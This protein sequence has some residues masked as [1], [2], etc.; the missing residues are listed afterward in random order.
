M[1]WKTWI[2]LVFAVVLALVA[3]KLTHNVIA[4][5]K[6][7]SDQGSGKFVQVVVARGNLSAGAELNAENLTLA[8][9]PGE[10]APESTYTAVTDLLGRVAAQ[11]F[12]LGQPI[13][14]KML[15]PKGAGTG[16]Q[17]LIPT[18]F[19]AVTLEINEFTGIAGLITPGMTVDVV[20]SFRDDSTRETVTRTVVQN[21]KVLAVGPRLSPP[22]SD[23]QKEMYKSVTLLAS[24]RDA[25]RV[26]LAAHTGRPRLAL[27]GG[28]DMVNIA[29]KGT[30][31]SDLAN[32]GDGNSAMTSLLAKFMANAKAAKPTTQPLDK[33]FAVEQPKAKPEVDLVNDIFE[34]PRTQQRTVK[35]IRN[36]VESNVIF[37]IPVQPKRRDLMTDTSEPLSEAK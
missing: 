24:P 15:A 35:I 22:Q 16:L 28:R 19:R 37:Q 3:A 2:P 12:V 21:L 18:G 29:T 26:E 9:M 31:L 14:E 8:P 27:R 6:G 33:T 23:E 30:S 32:P 7:A 1:N 13:N 25:E 11:P 20:S 36:G 4:G 17:A 10:A 34:Q 5:K